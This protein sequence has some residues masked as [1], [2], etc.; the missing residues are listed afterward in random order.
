[1][2][3]GRCPAQSCD[4]PGCRQAAP[5]SGCTVCLHGRLLFI[6]GMI[7]MAVVELHN[8]RFTGAA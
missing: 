3:V 1:M 5:H 6:A 8:N 4:W 7:T 2:L